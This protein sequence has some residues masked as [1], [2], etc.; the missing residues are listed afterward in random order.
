MLK[1]VKQTLI[2]FIVLLVL[3]LLTLFVFNTVA[4][5]G[6]LTA[7]IA[8]IFAMVYCFPYKEKVLRYRLTWLLELVKFFVLALAICSVAVLVIIALYSEPMYL[9]NIQPFWGVKISLLMPILLVGFY[10][11]CGPLQINSF[12][13]VLKTIIKITNYILWVTYIGYFIVH[14]YDVFI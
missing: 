10:Y 5:L 6:A 2:L 1:N 13:Y 11:F 4:I 8:P 12:F 9:N 14:Y 3:L 7:I